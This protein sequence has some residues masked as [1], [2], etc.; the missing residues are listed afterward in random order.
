LISGDSIARWRSACL[1]HLTV[2][3]NFDDDVL[4]PDQ[5]VQAILFAIGR[6]R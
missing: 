4:G 5:P 2:T 3:V 6:H 1:Y